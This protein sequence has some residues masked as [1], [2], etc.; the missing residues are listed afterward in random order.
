MSN[1]QHAV[2]REDALLATT[3]VADA[4]AVDNSS[5]IE[6]FVMIINDAYHT[7]YYGSPVDEKT[8]IDAFASKWY[9]SCL[10]SI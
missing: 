6:L 3:A 8:I 4:M 9:Q 5:V 7:S 10:Q 1:R 2:P